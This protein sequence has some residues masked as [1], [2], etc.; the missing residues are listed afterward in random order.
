VAAKDRY[1]SFAELS[2]REVEG[3]DYR[4]SLVPA[5]ASGVAIVAPHGGKIEFLT[6]EIARSIAADDHGFYAF[7]GTRWINNR[8]L[9]ITSS[10]FDEPRALALVSACSRVLTV[11]GLGG[12]ELGVQI[13]GLDEDLRERVNDSLSSAGFASEVV[14]AGQYGGIHPGNICNRGSSGAGVQLEIKYGLRRLLHR[15]RGRYEAFV[16]AVRTAIAD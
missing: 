12:H 9:H 2:R 14:A 5:G 8:V 1:A 4:I 10:R 3:R 11:H 7:E 6:T 15:D 13:G 16:A